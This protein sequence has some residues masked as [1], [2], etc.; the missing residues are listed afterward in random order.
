MLPV[1]LKKEAGTVSNIRR[2]M[3]L[4]TASVAVLAASAGCSGLREARDIKDAP[5]PPKYVE[6]RQR[7]FQPSEGSLWKDSAS[8]FEDRKARRINDLVTILVTERTTASKTAT[9]NANRE[10]S[11]DYAITQLPSGMRINNLPLVNDLTNGVRGNGTSDF[12]GKGDTSREGRMTATITAK[13]IEVLPN[14]NLVLEARKEVV[15]NNEK[16][17]IVFRGIVR[18]DDISP[19]NTILSQ[20]VA[21]AQIY[22]V[23]DGVLNDK[24]SQGWLVRLLDQVWPF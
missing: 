16:E 10:S 9:T 21:D 12:A 15:V 5:M 7:E 22:L 6:S 4:V 24:Q 20:N 18:P 17:I 11:A 19:T 23:G 13:V 1:T 2:S 14:D 8:L 3:V